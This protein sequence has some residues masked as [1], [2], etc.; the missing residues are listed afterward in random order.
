M[1]MKFIPH[2]IFAC[3]L[4]VA[5]SQPSGKS[6]AGCYRMVIKNDTATLSLNADGDKVTGSLNYNWFERDDN[7]GTFTGLIQNDTL[8]VADYTFQSEGVTSVRQVVFKIRDTTLLQGYGEIQT[9][10]DTALFRDVN[11]VIFDTKN[12]F[13]KGCQ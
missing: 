3:I 10:N 8:I 2:I 1:N 9:R 6:I 5:C 4:G 11:L 12:P 13:I 7:T